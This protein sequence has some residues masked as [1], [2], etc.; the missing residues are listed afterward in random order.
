MVCALL[1]TSV[2]YVLSCGMCFLATLVVCAQLSPL[3]V[4]A[5]L[6]ILVVCALVIIPVVCGLLIILVVY[7]LA[8]TL[9]VCFLLAI[10]GVRSASYPCG[11]SADHS[12]GTWSGT[13][14]SYVFR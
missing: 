5:L 4:C 13:I 11:M 12:F 14:L 9:V 7:A 8:A 6:I 2:M 3:A 10:C 1:V